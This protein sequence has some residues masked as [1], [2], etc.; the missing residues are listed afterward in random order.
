[1]KRSLLILILCLTI[2]FFAVSQQNDFFI[3]LS[4]KDLATF[5]DGITLMKLL[6]NERDDNAVYID[7]IIWAAGKKLFKVTIPIKTDQINPVLT[8]REF[9]YWI[10]KVFNTQG[11][12]VNRKKVNR[13]TAFRV[14][15]RLDII[16]K[17][18]GPFDSFTGE[19]LL[20]TFSYLD[21]YV[22]FNDI[23]PK[24]GELEL[25]DDTYKNLPEWREKLHRELDEQ[26]EMEKQLQE[27]KKEARKK[28]RQDTLKKI[29]GKERYIEKDAEKKIEE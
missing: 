28:K 7:N 11:G 20:D 10:V 5:N 1:M 26:Q 17:G 4:Q 27:K 15:E 2:S 19:E 9:A 8:R 13:Y 12:L 16:D 6:Y 3:E 22:R 23:R 25:P 18:R 29:T 24:K 21:Y 14:C